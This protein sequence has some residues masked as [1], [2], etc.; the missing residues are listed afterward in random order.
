[1]LSQLEK[2]SLDTDGRYASD[3]ELQ[4]VGDYMQSFSLRVQTYQKLQSAEAAIVQQV[5]AKMRSLDPSL[6]NSGNDDVSAKWKRDTVRVLRYSAVAM[7]MNDPETLR[8]RFLF[9]FQTIMK[10]FGAQKSCNATYVAMQEVVQQ[11]L[12]PIQA[13]LFCPILEI[14]RQTLGKA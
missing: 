11:H 6:F 8:E 2:L 14:N 4:F 10:A 9:W 1:M 13:S 3:E 7:L 12:T 5:E